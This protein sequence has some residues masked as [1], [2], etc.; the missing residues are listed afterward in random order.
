MC[1]LPEREKEGNMRK[2]NRIRRGRREKREEERK[3]QSQT[4]AKGV[5]LQSLKDKKEPNGMIIP[6]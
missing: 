2:W 6:E 5:G 4:N 3:V 1:F